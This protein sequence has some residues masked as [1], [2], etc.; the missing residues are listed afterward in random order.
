MSNDRLVLVIYICFVGNAILTTFIGIIHNDEEL[1]AIAHHKLAD[2][3]FG[4]FTA[5]TE[6]GL[7][8]LER[9]PLERLQLTSVQHISTVLKHALVRSVGHGHIRLIGP[10]MDLQGNDQ[11][12][13]QNRRG[14]GRHGSERRKV[15][16]EERI[17]KPP[18]HH[19]PDRLAQQFVAL[20][21]MKFVK[22]IFEVSGRRLLVA[23]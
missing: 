20:P 9:M 6:A 14:C 21:A 16:A 12:T 11:R 10:L 19:A 23:F 3:K 17:G 5:V 8:H 18:P 1:S 13:D 4:V 7:K 15:E 22:E 2:G